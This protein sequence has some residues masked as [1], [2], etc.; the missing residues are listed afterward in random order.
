[1]DALEILKRARELLAE[2]SSWIKHLAA[3]NRVAPQV[4]LQ[5]TDPHADCFCLIGAC[6][7][8][9]NLPVHQSIGATAWDDGNYREAVNML[10]QQ[11]NGDATDFGGISVP[12]F[13][14]DPSTTHADV[15]ELLDACIS[16]AGEKA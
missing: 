6:A 8:A 5:T 13:N 7:R 16:K 15:L 11:I 9:V 2:E 4:G 14:D 10:Y 12:I 1:M 3:A